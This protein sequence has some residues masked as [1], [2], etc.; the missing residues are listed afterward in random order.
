MSDDSVNEPVDADAFV[1]A[2]AV[3]GASISTLGDLLGSETVSATD[4]R[5]ARIDELQFDL[6]EGP[7]WDAVHT[8]R[9]V[10]EPDLRS[11]PRAHWPA[12]SRAVSAEDIGALFAIP[13]IVGPLRIGAVD[14]YDVRPRTLADA[15]LAK[16]TALAGVVGRQ[17]LRRAIGRARPAEERPSSFSRRIIHQATGF[18][19]AQVGVSAADAELLIQAR[20]FALGRTMQQVADDIVNRR[21]R[22]TMEGSGIEDGT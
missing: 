9:P 8:G 22:F 2:V 3:T 7:C 18:V 17:V 13:L 21:T 10:L 1:A 12:F 19:I 11:R 14:L 15:D 20:A 6:G 4:A 16:T 5:I